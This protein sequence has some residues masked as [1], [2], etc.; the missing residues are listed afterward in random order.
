MQS[1][2]SLHSHLSLPSLLSAAP[3]PPSMLSDCQVQLSP[4][5][6][7]LL[8][9]LRVAGSTNLRLDPSSLDSTFWSPSFKPALASHPPQG[10]LAEHTM[11]VVAITIEGICL[12]H[13]CQET[14][15]SCRAI[16]STHLL[17][18]EGR[19]APR[20]WHSTQICLGVDNKDVSIR[21][22]GDPELVA[23]QDIVIS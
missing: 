13:R 16:P 10:A 20:S 12:W 5:S 15:S 6:P 8:G 7:H 1:L 9:P 11:T 18:D 2:F 22:I 23:I 4:F 19:D 17:H 14:K 21:A 3:A